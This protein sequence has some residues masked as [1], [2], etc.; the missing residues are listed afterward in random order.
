VNPAIL[1]FHPNQ[2]I[3][4]RIKRTG[5][6]DASTQEVEC[7][8]R[9]HISKNSAYG[10]EWNYAHDGQ[11]EQVVVWN[12]PLNSFT[13]ITGFPGNSLGALQSGW[14]MRLDLVGDVITRYISTD[15]GATWNLIGTVTDTTWRSGNPGAGFWKNGGT[16]NAALGF[17]R[18]YAQE[19]P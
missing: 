12:G 11:Y 14:L 10:Y 4:G 8:G 13:P 19:L 15:N 18:W 7:L 2:R 1:A 3:I 5:S 16:S 17:D 9:F 6:V